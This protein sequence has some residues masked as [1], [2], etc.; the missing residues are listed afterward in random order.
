M[1]IQ[2]I[3]T[4]QLNDQPFHEL[5]SIGNFIVFYTTGVGLSQ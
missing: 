5:P 4:K 1:T 3:E 2:F